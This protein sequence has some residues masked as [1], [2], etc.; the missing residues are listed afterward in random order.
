[1]YL[2]LFTSDANSVVVKLYY[3]DTIR[4]KKR[5]WDAIRSLRTKQQ[6]TVIIL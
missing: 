6:G 2:Q 3:R 4:M 1:M 5:Y